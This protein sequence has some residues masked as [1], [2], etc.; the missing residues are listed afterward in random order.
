M[1][2]K[3]RRAD[4]PVIPMDPNVVRLQATD[5]LETADALR[6]HA[7]SLADRWDRLPDVYLTSH[8]DLAIAEI[9]RVADGL[10]GAANAYDAV[11]VALKNLS[12]DLEDVAVGIARLRHEVDAFVK[13]QA[14]EVIDAQRNAM[15]WAAR[16]LLSSKVDNAISICEQRLLTVPLPP[17][18]PTL[19]SVEDLHWP[20]GEPGGAMLD[21]YALL[22]DLLFAKLRPFM[23]MP[24][25]ADAEAMLEK[26]GVRTGEVDED[27]SALE[28]AWILWGLANGGKL[29]TDPNNGPCGNDMICVIGDLPTGQPGNAMTLGRAAVFDTNENEPRPWWQLHEYAHVA[30]QVDAGA[31]AFLLD[32]G[33]EFAYAASSGEDSHDGNILEQSS[34]LRAN[35]AEDLM[36]KGMDWR[37]AFVE[38]TYDAGYSRIEGNPIEWAFRD[39]VLG[40][41]LNNGS[42]MQHL[43][44]RMG[45]PDTVEWDHR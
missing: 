44:D 24:L 37:E 15:L 25:P 41:E 40:Q 11:H 26:I 20:W 4:V 18:V 33:A 7:T 30:D 12:D 1:E 14:T 9:G 38:S 5:L 45:I 42:R 2:R 19:C 36:K 29:Y 6:R 28:R 17:G 3:I 43:R 23:Y 22:G 32:Y 8:T 21:P 34:N 16:N 13:N 39:R 10:R 31:K 35:F 27:T